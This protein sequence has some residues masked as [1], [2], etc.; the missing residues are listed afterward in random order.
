MTSIKVIGGGLAG[1]EASYQLAERG[2]KV[3]L[4]EMR[5][6][7]ETRTHQT[8]DLAELVC[9]NSL[10]S[11]DV[12]NGAGLLKEE[13]RHCGSLILRMADLHKVPAGGALAVDRLDFSRSVTE[14]I[15]KHPNIE[16]IREEISEIPTEGYV[17]VASGPLTEGAL[18]KSI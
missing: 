12:T 18:A 13:L 10:R 11:T 14:A 5:P 16:I 6:K 4:Y 17:I 2:H 1:S 8:G 3:T 9:S 15:E 7:V